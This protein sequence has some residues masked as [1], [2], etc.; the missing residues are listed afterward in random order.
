MNTIKPIHSNGLSS[1]ENEKSLKTYVVHNPVSGTSDAEQVHE[2]ITESLQERGVPYE[3]YQTTGK[4]DIHDIVKKAIA[5]GFE[6]FV[7]IGGDGTIQGVASG[8]VHTD[9]PLVMVPTGTVNALAREL[10][11]PFALEDS[12]RWW[13]DSAERRRIDVVEANKR[14]YLLNVSVGTAAS[15]MKNVKREDINRFGVLPYIREAL[16]RMNVPM[17]RFKVTIDDRSFTVRASEIF[18]ANSGV[19]LG[20]AA[21]RLDPEASLD[22]GKLS[23]CR[24]RLQTVFDYVRMAFKIAVKPDSDSEELNCVDALR[25]VR[26]EANGRVPVQGDGELIGNT[27]VTVRLIPHALNV[28]VPPRR[29]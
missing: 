7:A 18:I 9:L 20:L 10:D 13:M 21:L 5:N 29:T 19:L 22:S 14:Y 4:E 12:V 23:V 3:I 2:K 25:E 6:R 11:I 1:M 27:P 15:I 16:R 26:I 28:I 8:L 24:A 17:Y